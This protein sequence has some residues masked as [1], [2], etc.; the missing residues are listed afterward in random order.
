MR[1]PSHVFIALLLGMVLASCAPVR[2][3]PAFEVV[4]LA[5]E[6]DQARPDHDMCSSLTLTVADVT[7]YFRLADEVD[8]ATFHDQAMIL[9]CSYRGSIK[10]SGQ[11]RQYQIFAGGA[12]YLYDNNGLNKRYLCRQRCLDALPGLQ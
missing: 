5:R 7:S 1:R 3:D 2:H 10:I 9:P 6:I 12:A 8:P 11:L 4:S